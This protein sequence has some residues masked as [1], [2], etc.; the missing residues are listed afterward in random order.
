[1]TCIVVEL[2]QRK[3]A[4]VIHLCGEHETNLLFSLLRREMDHTLDILHCIPVAIAVAQAAVNKRR[5]PGPRECHKAVVG[6]PHIDHGVKGR[7]RRFDMEPRELFLPVTAQ[8]IDF[9]CADCLRLGI[10]CHETCALRR[11]LFTQKE[12][13]SLRLSGHEADHRR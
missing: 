13:N 10:A 1:M 2:H 6:V 12:R 11:S 8:S 7:G 9:R 5:C 3:R 4:A